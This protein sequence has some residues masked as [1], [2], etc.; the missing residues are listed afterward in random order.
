[1]RH[2]A[3]KNRF[4]LSGSFEEKRCKTRPLSE[5]W[6]IVRQINSYWY[7]MARQINGRTTYAPLC[8]MKFRFF[9]R[10]N[11]IDSGKF[12]IMYP[13]PDS[14]TDISDKL[15]YFRLMKSLKQ[16]D[17]ADLLGINRTTYVRYEENPE[18][19]P[20]DI[21]LKIA[22]TIDTDPREIISDEYCELQLNNQGNT[23][24]AIR[25]SHGMTQCEFA[26]CLGVYD[27]TVKR[28]ENNRSKIKRETYEKIMQM[29]SK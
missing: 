14:V 12:N 22:V 10:Q 25:K 17:I 11:L 21:L 19:I 4:P 1:M 2:G 15:K 27:S 16:R 13:S 29:F 18:T 5:K 28:W 23:L 24:R 26:R 20:I 3:Y 9:K 7:L 8:H 6:S